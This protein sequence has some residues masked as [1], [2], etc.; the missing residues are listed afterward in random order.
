MGAVTALPQVYLHHI[1]CKNYT[2][3]K[4]NTE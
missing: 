1:E 4:K 2:P 3:V